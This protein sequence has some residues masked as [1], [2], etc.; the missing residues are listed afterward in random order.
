M[1]MLQLIYEKVIHIRPVPLA[2]LITSHK[3]TLPHHEELTVSSQP[4]KI[5]TFCFSPPSEPL[6]RF[7]NVFVYIITLF[8]ITIN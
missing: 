7:I 2:I 6:K 5:E 8:F 3:S 4:F 1:V